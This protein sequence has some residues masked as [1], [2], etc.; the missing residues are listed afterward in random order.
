[1]NVTYE[2]EIVLNTLE[3]LIDALAVSEARKLTIQPK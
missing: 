1:V 2:Y 3:R